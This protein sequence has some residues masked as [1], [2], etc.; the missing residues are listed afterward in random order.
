[1]TSSIKA[2]TLALSL[3]ALSPLASAQETDAATQNDSITT[4]TESDGAA[5]NEV[6]GPE[7]T[8]TGTDTGTDATGTD[9]ATDTAG[10]ESD[11]AV[12]TEVT[13]AE[14][15]AAEGTTDAATDVS[16]A[17]TDGATDTAG[18]ENDAVTTTSE[19]DGVAGNERQ[20]PGF[21]WGLLGLAGLAGLA[22]RRAVEQRRE[23]RLGG[24]TDGPRPS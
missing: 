13:G 16:G 10:T 5:G 22:G 12:G 15:A 23:V 9:A 11:S 21:P 19:S 20:G 18:T 3:F 8:D 6:Q 2:L 17:S 7:G 1:M 14:D 24:P 4:Q